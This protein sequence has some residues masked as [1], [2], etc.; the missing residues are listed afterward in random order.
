[1]PACPKCKKQ[2]PSVFSVSRHLSQPLS[3]CTRRHAH[4]VTATLP[5]AF[6]PPTP[7]NVPV[8][9][10][11]D[12]VIDQDYAPYDAD[13]IAP[14]AMD[15]DAMAIDSNLPE[16]QSTQFFRESFAGAGS[17]SAPGTTFMQKFN[18][19]Q[20]QYSRARSENIYYPFASRQDWQLGYFLLSSGMSMTLI[21]EFLK[22]DLVRI[23]F[24]CWCTCLT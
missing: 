3:A 14:E 1:M 19:E 5:P 9:G 10:A 4:L 15:P 21:N 24:R 11:E 7:A 22:L 16:F 13:I 17:I 12:E 8:E 2:F 18:D 20:P 23:P 6:V